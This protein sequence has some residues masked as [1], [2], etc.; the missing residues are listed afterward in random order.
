MIAKWVAVLLLASPAGIAAARPQQPAQEKPEQQQAQAQSQ[1]GQHDAL[2]AA[3][4]RTRAEQKDQPQ[5]AKVWTNDNIPKTP[6]AISIVGTPAP[7][8]A[9]AAAASKPAEGTAGA[10]GS[11][12][13]DDQKAQLE[14]ELQQTKA[15]LKSVQTDLDIAT[16][17]YD[18]DRQMFFSN[19]DYASDTQGAAKLK[20]QEGEIAAKK[21]EISDLQKNV[22]GLTEKLQ[23][24]DNASQESSKTPQ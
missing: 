22:D 6:G 8:P 11:A 20:G 18:L 15:H 24:L 23:N 1:T 7:A 2:A 3:A 10:E 13:V 21:Q 14:K 5:A 9:P 12:S 19:P 16:R 4:R 17:T